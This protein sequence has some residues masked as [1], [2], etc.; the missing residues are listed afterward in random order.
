MM[1][2]ILLT[3]KDADIIAFKKSLGAESWSKAVDNILSAALR[4]RIAEVPMDFVILPIEKSVQAKIYLP[5][6]LVA[7]FSERF[8][9]GK[10]NLTTHIKNEIRRC[11]RKNLC[12]KQ[13][14]STK[15]E[16]LFAK[17]KNSVNEKEKRYDGV[18]EK[19]KFVHK[20]VFR[21]FDELIENLRLNCKGDTANEK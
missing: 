18:R 3:K 5:D 16:V 19:N 17:V 15:A 14:S 12:P 10:G 8:G 1:L 2:N 4:E 11:I 9:C 6:K 20:E 21:V 7:K 13:I